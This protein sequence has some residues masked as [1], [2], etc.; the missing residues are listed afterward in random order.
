M[1]QALPGQQ[2]QAALLR[3]V[4]RLRQVGP[5][6]ALAQHGVGRLGQG[7]PLTLAQGLLLAEKVGN[8]AVGRGVELE[9]L[10]D[11]LGREVEERFRMHG[12]DYPLLVCPGVPI[13]VG[14]RCV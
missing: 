14:P 12:R 10:T 1:G 6:Q 9:H 7:V 2:G 13:L 3:A 11:E 4:A 5:Q 8:D